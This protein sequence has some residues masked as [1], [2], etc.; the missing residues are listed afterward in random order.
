MGCD[1]YFFVSAFG[2]V[3]LIRHAVNCLAHQTLGA[4]SNERGEAEALTAEKL[5]K[6]LQRRIHRGV[7]RSRF[8]ARREGH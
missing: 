2:A 4:A 5:V 1:G 8:L 3:C 7:E 6:R